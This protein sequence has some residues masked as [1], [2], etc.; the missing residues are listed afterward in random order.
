MAHQKIKNTD[1]Y[2]DWNPKYNVI[3]NYSKPIKLPILNKDL[4]Y[5]ESIV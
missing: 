2:T 4:K 1:V 3:N 5:N